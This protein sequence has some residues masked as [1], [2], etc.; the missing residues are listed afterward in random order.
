M[1]NKGEAYLWACR[2]FSCFEFNAGFESVLGPRFF[3]CF[4]SIRPLAR[5]RLERMILSM[6]YF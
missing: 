1:T 2:F 6:T 5:M 3:C 4:P